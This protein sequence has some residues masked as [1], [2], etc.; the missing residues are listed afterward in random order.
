MRCSYTCVQ[1]YHSLMDIPLLSLA[2]EAKMQRVVQLLLDHPHCDIH[3]VDERENSTILHV[4]LLKGQYYLLDQLLPRGLLLKADKRGFTPFHIAARRGKLEILHKFFNQWLLENGHQ[5]RLGADATQ[6][7]QPGG[8]GVGAS[9]LDADHVTILPVTSA[10]GM[11][12]DSITRSSLTVNHQMNAY[13]ITNS[14]VTS[15]VW[16]DTEHEVSLPHSQ[17]KE[18]KLEDHLESLLA[19]EICQSWKSIRQLRLRRCEVLTNLRVKCSD[20]TMLHLAATGAHVSTVKYLVAHGADVNFC[21]KEHMTP[22]MCLVGG[23]GLSQ[24]AEEVAQVLIE[25]GSD[26]NISGVF[27]QSKPCY[28][29]MTPLMAAARRNNIRMVDLLLEAGASMLTRG[30]RRDDDRDTA[31]MAAVHHSSCEVAWHML[32]KYPDR[33]EVNHQN[34]SG[35]SAL[36]MVLSCQR[37][38]REITEL[39]LQCGA[40]VKLVNSSQHTPLTLAISQGALDMVEAILQHYPGL[41]AGPL[42]HPSGPYPCWQSTLHYCMHPTHD[43]NSIPMMHLL[44]RHGADINATHATMT[45]LDKSLTVK[46][47]DMTHFLILLGCRVRD[48][49]LVRSFLSSHQAVSQQVEKERSKKLSSSQS[50]AL[51]ALASPMPHETQT[52][53]LYR[54]KWVQ[55]SAESKGDDIEK[56]EIRLEKIHAIVTYLTKHLSQ[57]PSLHS[58]CLDAIRNGVRRVG[59][60]FANAAQLPLPGSIINTILYMD[61][62]RHLFYIK[63]INVIANCKP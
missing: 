17:P 59:Q 31:L 36:H 2:C 4:A 63:K 29:H 32:T 50:Q 55:T 47:I 61:D 19:E 6:D 41:L 26:C 42:S 38:R 25:A 21:N 44:L 27:S 14:P 58:L 1:G 7:L 11:E 54:Q 62:P 3:L 13:S 22:L 45:P 8:Q 37:K 40:D 35:D 56:E 46:K 39:L 20:N 30:E 12:A 34:Q 23:A 28:Y 15:A 43:C 51:P 5:V 16:R 33:V 60:S 24:Q 49:I 52:P 10:S 9:H 53:R 57:P 48:T 18:A